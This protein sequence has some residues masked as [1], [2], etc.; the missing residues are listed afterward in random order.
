MTGEFSNP[1]PNTTVSI[2]CTHADVRQGNTL[3]WY[4]TNFFLKEINLADWKTDR[5]L[6]RLV[7]QNKLRSIMCE[8]KSA[9]LNKQADILEKAKMEFVSRLSL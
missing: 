4:K 3:H 1:K 5:T 9:T 2:I 6:R 7:D 8:I